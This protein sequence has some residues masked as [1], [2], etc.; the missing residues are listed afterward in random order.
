MKYP[1]GVKTLSVSEAVRNLAALLKQAI[2]GEE[3]GIR[4]DDTVVV[5]R[6]LQSTASQKITPRE[7]LR[8]LQLEAHLTPAEAGSYLQEVYAERVAAEKRSA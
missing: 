2:A 5:L 3:I 6:P 4:S 1:I 8:R 7:A